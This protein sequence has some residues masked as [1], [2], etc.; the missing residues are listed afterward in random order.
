MHDYNTAIAI[1]PGEAYVYANRAITEADMGDYKAAEKDYSKA[2]IIDKN[3]LPAYLN[4]AIMREKL[5]DQEGAIADCNMA[6][7]LNMFQMMLMV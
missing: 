5:G 4:R 3:L 7:K 1:N 6:I 2:L